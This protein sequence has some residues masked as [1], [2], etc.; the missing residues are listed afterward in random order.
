MWILSPLSWLLPSIL[1][2]AVGALLPRRRRW[3]LVLGG[4]GMAVSVLAMTPVV[5]NR[6]VGWLEAMPTQPAA[7]AVRPPDVA[8]VL[9]GGVDR[10]AR[11][12]DDVSVLSIG[13]RRRAEKA[14]GW[15]LERPGR[16]LVVAG[17]SRRAVP[18][19]ILLAGYLRR[20]GVPADAI[21]TETRSLDTWE[22]A[23]NLAAMRPALPREVVLVTSAMHMRRADY[24]MREA[25]FLPCA[26][27]ADWRYVPFRRWRYLLP[28]SGGLDKTEAALHELVGLAVYRIRH[29][30]AEA[31]AASV[32]QE[33]PRP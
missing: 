26:L 31:P 11:S 17:G 6:L 16:T 18:E 4:A 8:V 12:E 25:G 30:G 14:L 20:L 7:C 3:L 13:S 27:G 22:N 24:S 28:D 1:V 15:W 2:F 10:F 32:A 33:P 9:A 29:R 5:A 19:A 23:R 21:R